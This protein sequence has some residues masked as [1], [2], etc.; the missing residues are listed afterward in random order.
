MRTRRNS[1]SGSSATFL[2]G[3]SVSRRSASVP[4]LSLSGVSRSGLRPPSGPGTSDRRAQAVEHVAHL[5][6]HDLAHDLGHAL[7]EGDPTPL[8]I[9]LRRIG[10]LVVRGHVLGPVARQ[11]AD[12]PVLTGKIVAAIMQV[13]AVAVPRQGDIAAMGIHARRR[14]HMGAVHR[15][16][17]RLVDGR[18][19]AMVDPVVV[20]E[21]EAH[22]SAI[23]GLHGHGLRADLL[24]GPER[25]VLHAKAA[26]VLQEHDAIPA[27][28]VSRAALDRHA[29]LIAQ[30][31]GSPH[32]LA[33]RLVERAH[34]VVGVG[35]DDPAAIR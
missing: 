14:Q 12:K 5:L 6:R 23:V 10:T 15:H 25:A 3:A 27:G 7:A 33:R 8:G 26:L 19:I 2:S 16:A 24:D 9:A 4:L 32:P 31:A 22:G 18:G 1:F 20:L 17:L 21:V 30:I 29:H 13:H 28:E 35:E 11:G 34:L